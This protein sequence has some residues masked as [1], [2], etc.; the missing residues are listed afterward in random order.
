MNYRLEKLVLINQWLTLIV[1]AE[2]LGPLFVAIQELPFVDAI[3]NFIMLSGDA[4][5]PDHQVGY[6]S[7]GSQICIWVSIDSSAKHDFCLDWL[8]TLAF[9]RL[10]R[11]GTLQAWRPSGGVSG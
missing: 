11:M 4:L 8:S 10:E 6:I 9:H 2:V 5:Y 1:R 3:G 7:S